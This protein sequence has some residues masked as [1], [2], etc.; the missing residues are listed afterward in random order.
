MT[1][2][3]NYHKETENKH[4]WLIRTADLE[5]S[6]YVPKWRVP[7]PTPAYIRVTIVS[8]HDLPEKVAHLTFEDVNR[9][10]ERAKEPILVQLTP[11]EEL[12]KT[13]RFDPVGDPDFWEIGS[14]YISKDVFED[15]P[16]DP[17]WL[18]IRWES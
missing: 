7:E 8:N 16:P 17:M 1:F 10:P 6:V 18:S 9:N 15:G 5:F 14:P 11:V 4:R 3:L 2:D 13:I 12:T